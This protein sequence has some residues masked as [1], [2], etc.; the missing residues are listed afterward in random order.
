MIGKIIEF[1][2]KNR[3]IVFLLVGMATLAGFYSMKQ[4]PLD[5]IPDLSDT[6]VIVYSRW[7]R[8][9][10][11]IE[12][13]VTYPIITAL[14]GAPKVKAIRGFSDFGFSYVYIIFEEGTDIYW[15]RSRTIEYL[16]KILPRLPEGVETEIGPDATGVGWVF[17][18]ALLDET[19]KRNLQ[20]LRSF[21]D[22]FLRYQLQSVPGVA[23]VASIGGYGKQ[24]Q[25]TI[26]PNKL[27]A[28]NMPISKIIN[29]IR[30]G[31]VEVGGK[32]L[33]FSGA[34]YMVRGRGYV[35]S[36]E[37]IEDISLGSDAKGI[38]I[39]IKNVA[40][41][42]LGPDIRRGV[43]DLDGRGDVVGGIV[44]M[45]YKEN[46]LNVITRV[47]EKLKEI[48][49]SLPEGLKIEITYDRSQLIKESIGTVKET[50]I[51][52]LIIIFVMIGFFLLHFPSTMI[53]II[54]IPIAILIAFIPLLGMK[55]T[56]NIMS[57]GGIVIAI[58]DMVDA[59][60][61]IVENAHKRL[62]EWTRG[63]RKGTR[64]EVLIESMKEVGPAI[65][66]SLIVI[67]IAFMPVFTLEAQ[68]GRLF[69]PL[70]FTKNFAIFFSAL[71]AIT[72][73]PALVITFIKGKI[74]SEEKNPV[75]RF[76][77][78]CYTP[79]V[80][81]AIKSR[82]LVILIAVGAVLV[83][84]PA[85]LKIGSEFMPPL[86]EGTI[87]YMPSTLPGL[88]VTEA[89]NLIQ[90]QDKVLKTFP[91]VERVFGKAG[92]ADTSTDPAP[93][94]MME[95]TIILKSEKDWRFVRR[96]YS[97]LPSFLKFPFRA[98]WPERLS[99]E[100]LIE[101]MDKKLQFAGV[102]NAWT[103]P[104]KART[105]MLTTGIRT[106]IGIKIYGSDINKI[107]E[108]GTHLENILKDI[109][110]TRSIYAERVG[111]GYFVD[112]DLKRK[113]L[114]RYELSVAEAQMVI[115]SAI[116]GENIS[117]TVE[118][119]ERYPINVRYVRDL[120][121]NIEK[122][123]RAL[124]PT[125]SGAQI[126]LAQIADIEVRSGPSMIRDEN[127]LLSGY[128]YVD[129]AGRDVGGYVTEAKR[130]VR[131]KLNLPSGYSLVWSG[132]YEFM[133]RVKE[134]L[135][136]FVPLTIAII[137]ILYYFT[138]RSVTETSI[139]MLSV[140]FALVG[141]IWAV[142]LLG[143]NMS[144]AVWVGFIALAG[145][146]VETGSVM[147]TYL[148]EVYERKKKEQ[149]MNSIDDLYK[150]IIEGAAPR[151]RPIFM[152]VAA[153]IFGLVPVMWSTGTGAD[154]M[155]RIAAPVMGGLTS[156]TILTLIVL[157]AIYMIWKGDGGMK[158]KPKKK[159]DDRKI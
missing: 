148:D 21:Q 13:Q 92:R 40:T 144:I 32:L 96:W 85:Y 151:I 52:E 34:E 33:E 46:A 97:S 47:K 109:K 60:I 25:V 110:G 37:D 91:E 58:G 73:I 42:Q 56:S 89:A 54:V 88:S 118:G 155:K 29:A 72:L 119:R 53:P 124:V 114:A 14:L 59:S 126:P 15:A 9:P 131:E 82:K 117:I 104:I 115:M 128:V 50:L 101:E 81:W 62:D 19:G 26:D 1:S 10:D 111:G 41:V 159:I 61:I 5:A 83:T 130:I 127:G 135:K 150:A 93:F 63:L 16:S 39:T 51:E 68:E 142:L 64:E 78:K 23:E 125:P 28:Y 65:F 152:T 76:L 84:V 12:D 71:L 49:P 79:V 55:L 156:S 18:Y 102:T 87:L 36:V 75:S 69:K 157:P 6:Q 112:F 3:F 44:V 139:I 147:L 141:G 107:E 35:K 7:D 74:I 134:R 129:M 137:F 108:L 86:N 4:I 122:L 70:A 43:A 133:Q 24:Y 38:P 80:D 146:A 120:R 143:Y 22:W 98:F 100:Q 11:I 123:K 105:D 27:L 116:G 113:E 103:M 31:N 45:R 99:Y 17:Q 145:I 132:Q 94:S 48:E 57:L 30:D 2:A 77:V 90:T 8:S 66:A 140:P 95:T 121:D 149:K 158:E 153:N 138:F 154:V 20:E 67:A 106:P 136:I